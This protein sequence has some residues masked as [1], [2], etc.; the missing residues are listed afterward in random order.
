MRP[1][2]GALYET[3]NMPL[4]TF[5]HDHC[6]LPFNPVGPGANWRGSTLLN[7]PL[8]HG[9][10]KKKKA[11]L[12]LCPLEI[13]PTRSFMRNQ[14]PVCNPVVSLYRHH[15]PNDFT[16]SPIAPPCL[17]DFF[18][19]LTTL[20][21]HDKETSVFETSREHGGLVISITTTICP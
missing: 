15:Q 7:L 19:K 1:W 4:C 17:S 10:E 12:R 11:Q 16:E 5:R 8:S 9:K 2:E 18:P 13:S 6:Y 21:F 3:H 14:V 20:L